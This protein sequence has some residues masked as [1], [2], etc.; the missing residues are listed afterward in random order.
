MQRGLVLIWMLASLF[1]ARLLESFELQPIVRTMATGIALEGIA[2]GI[3]SASRSVDRSPCHD[4]DDE[5]LAR[6]VA[7]MPK[8]QA[9]GPP[10]A[11]AAEA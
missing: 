3:G 6:G 11:S 9:R 7:S 8:T 2:L 10:H 4:L 5:D 1:V